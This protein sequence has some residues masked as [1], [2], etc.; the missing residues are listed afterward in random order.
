MKKKSAPQKFNS[1]P[2]VIIS[3]IIAIL[4]MIAFT[5]MGAYL[6]VKY[7]L[8]LD[9]PPQ[10]ISN[11]NTNV[12]NM[13]AVLT[14]LATLTPTR[15]P[16]TPTPSCIQYKIREGEFASDK[17]YSSSD[18]S[19]LEYQINKLNTAVFNYN[20]TV[21]QV[22]VTCNGFTESFKQECEQGKK[23]LERYNKDIEDAKNAIRASI[24]KGR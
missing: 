6:G 2:V 3:L 16:F 23:D 7:F 11:S 1:N 10:N 13:D 21:N 17:C 22:N 14:P 4:M 24:A 19:D 8:Q 20:G 9:P 5:A 18:L 15:I 12:E